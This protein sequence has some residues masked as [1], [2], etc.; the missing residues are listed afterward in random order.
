MDNFYNNFEI[1]CTVPGIKSG[2]A[3]SYANAIKYLCDFLQVSPLNS[4]FIN[5][6]DK[7]SLKVSNKNCKF[8]QDFLSFLIKRNQGS[9]LSNGYVKAAIPQFKLFNSK[10]NKTKNEITKV[11]TI[12]KVIDLC[13]GVATWDDIY[14]KSSK[15]YPNI[16]KSVEWKAG[17]RGVLYRELRNN[18]SFKRNIDNSFSLL[19]N[20]DIKIP[21]VDSQE[22]NFIIEALKDSYISVS[23]DKDKILGIIPINSTINHNY[24]IKNINGTSKNASSKIY[25]GRKAEKYFLN[26]LNKNDFKLNTDYFDVSNNKNFGYDI[27]FKNFGLEIKNIKSGCFYLTDTEIAYLENKKTHL[28]LVDID[29][30]IWILK[31]NSNWLKNVI[32]NIKEIRNYCS[33]KYTNIDLSE[34]KI[35]ID[36]T[37][38]TDVTEISQYTHNEICDIILN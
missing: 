11:E 13:G 14:T 37:I 12:K 27:N 24:K 19:E 31:N 8:Y 15:F 4:E 17:L 35:N 6:I 1:F 2:K 26:F 9:Y 18:K 23:F 29:N 21:Q 32:D 22:E 34:I 28:I 33:K 3:K 7:I 30:G 10:L 25:S 16:D 5:N 38:E 36:N 20:N